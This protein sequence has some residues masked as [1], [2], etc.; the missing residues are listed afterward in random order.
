MISETFTGV[1]VGV[2]VGCVGV[3]VVVVVVVVCT[4]CSS[5]F[6]S[7]LCNPSDVNCMVL[8]A[9]ACVVNSSVPS[10]QSHKSSLTYEDGIIV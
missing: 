9:H 4:L 2:G 8:I 6:F 3:V 5:M 1:G 7:L 10:L